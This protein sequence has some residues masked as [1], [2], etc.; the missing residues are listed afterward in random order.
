MSELVSD[1]RRQ[2]EH[3]FQTPP[4]NR[5]GRV[6]G[7]RFGGAIER[8]DSPLSI[9]GGQAA[10]EAIDDV[11]VE[12]LKIRNLARRTLESRTGALQSI[13]ERSTQERD[14]EKQKHVEPSRVRHDAERWQ[15]ALVVQ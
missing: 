9:G 1:I 12:C 13:G 4:D 10:R 14:R 5:E 11:L 7:N 8:Q 6:P 2:L 3:L 15:R